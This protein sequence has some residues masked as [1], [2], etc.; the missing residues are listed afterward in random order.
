M[1][2]VIWTVCFELVAFPCKKDLSE[3]HFVKS[4][5]EESVYVIYRQDSQS[6]IV[7][8]NLPCLLVV[9]GEDFPSQK[10]S[11]LQKGPS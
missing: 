10:A 6:N 7:C 3:C 2:S 8:V 9:P 1:G 4:D 5:V 11:L